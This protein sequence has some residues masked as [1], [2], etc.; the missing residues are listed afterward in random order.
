M[1]YDRPLTGEQRRISQLNYNRFSAVNGASYMCL[2]ETVIILFAVK[3]S[4]PNIIVA[5]IGAMMFLGFL[6]LPL[7]VI[8]TAQ[9]GAARS[10]ADFWVCRNVAAL[11]VAVSALILPLSREL[12]WGTLLL[13][14]FLFYGFRAAG[15]VM[16]QPL[17]GDISSNRDRSRLIA[18]STGLFYLTGLLAM[19]AISLLLSVFDNLYIL[20]AIIVAGATMGVT[21]SGFIRK[22]DETDDLRRSARKPLLPQLREA[23]LDSTLTRQMWAGFMVNLSI[24]MLAPISILA[25][26]R[27]YGVSDTRAIL[28][29]LV[30]FGSAIPATVLTAR[31]TE[32]IGPRKVIICGYFLNFAICL[33]WILAPAGS[34]VTSPWMWLLFILPFIFIGTAMIS[35]QNAMIHYF[36]MS[37][38]KDRQVAS[39]MFINVATGAAAGVTGMILAGGLL[40]YGAR[41]SG[42]EAP[43]ETMFRYY[44]ALAG[45]IF[46]AGSWLVLR[47]APVIDTFIQDNGMEK[48]RIIIRENIV[49]TN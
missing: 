7:G 39:S 30:Q 33:F 16:S 45:V 17:I 34:A 46:L 1:L 2:G 47:L 25:V 9:V 15:V 3:L 18:R 14:S 6:L 40:K 36:L 38:P 37:V 22:I 29:S 8:R 28:F 20:A 26:K 19:L 12:A 5:V 48:T 43:P 13:G 42:P 35:M 41:F 23:L 24:I 49:K 27:G 21:A 11:L 10:Q 31:I 4:A 32:K 44:F